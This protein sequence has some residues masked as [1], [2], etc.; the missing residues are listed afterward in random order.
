[1]YPNADNT[2]VPQ[3]EIVKESQ[4][5]EE[6]KKSKLVESY[7]KWEG[8]P[9]EGMFHSSWSVIKTLNDPKEFKKIWNNPLKRAQFILSLNDT[10]LMALM[11]LILTALFAGIVDEDNW[12]SSKDV[13]SATRESGMIPDFGYK[14]FWGMTQ[15]SNIFNVVSSMFSDVNPPLF[16]SIKKL[17]STIGSTL[18]GN[19]GL[20][21]AIVSQFGALKPL[22]TTIREWEQN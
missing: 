16:T 11:S 10:L 19:T 14:V 12:W 21:E 1:M 6:D 7:I 17:A 5:T 8:D 4:L 22:Q 20:A 2:G 13:M 18:A 3:K 9:M 15:D